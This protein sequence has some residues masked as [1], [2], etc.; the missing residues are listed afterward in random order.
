MG[1]LLPP[2]VWRL[3]FEACSLEDSKVLAKVSWDLRQVCR[4]C[5]VH[6]DLIFWERESLERLPSG[7]RLYPLGDPGCVWICAMA[8]GRG[9]LLPATH[10]ELPSGSLVFAG[11]YFDEALEKV[12]TPN[13]S[14]R[15]DMLRKVSLEED[16]AWR[17][18]ACEEASHGRSMSRNDARE[19][20]SPLKRLGSASQI[21]ECSECEDHGEEA[22]YLTQMCDYLVDTD[23]QLV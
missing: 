11:Q 20:Y 9:I 12:R 14:R 22:A 1:I 19:S 17:V 4:V 2:E 6:R 5:L 15:V 10:G 7:S 23:G 18:Q 13:G 21:K 3:V 8:C 16:I